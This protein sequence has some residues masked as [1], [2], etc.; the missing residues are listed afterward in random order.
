MDQ[1]QVVPVPKSAFFPAFLPRRAR[2]TGQDSPGQWGHSAQRVASV[3]A[4]HGR[5]TRAGSQWT[6]EIRAQFLHNLI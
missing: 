2:Q 4:L 6:E 1:A 3:P 5:I